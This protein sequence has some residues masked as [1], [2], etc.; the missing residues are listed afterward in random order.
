MERRI[1]AHRITDLVDLLIIAAIGDDRD[2]VIWNIGG[3]R[4]IEC[5]IDEACIGKIVVRR[6]GSKR[7]RASISS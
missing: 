6:N 2:G 5:E 3:N 7:R 1:V 4:A